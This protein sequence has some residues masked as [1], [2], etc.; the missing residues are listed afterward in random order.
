MNGQ[1]VFAGAYVERHGHLRRDQEW[2]T[3]AARSD[4]SWFVPVWGEWCLAAGEPVHTVLLRRDAVREYIDEN[5]LVFLGKFR[6]A[7]AFAVHIDR[8]IPAPFSDLG[9]FHDLRYLGSVLP[10]DEANLV[11]HARALIIWNAT[12]RFCGRCGA[13]TRVESGGNTRMCVNADCSTRSFPRVDPAIIVL[14][15]KGD[16]CL[17]GRE[18]S[19][20]EGRYST[21]AG[22][23]EPG[24]SLED[25]VVREVQ[26][27]TNIAVEDVVYHSSQPWPFPA[28]IMLG[29][30]ARGTTDAVTRNDGE[31]EDAR[32]FTRKELAS[33]YPKLS[34][35]LSI[36]RTLI[37][38]WIANEHQQSNVD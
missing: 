30:T 12:Q 28:S 17:L 34:P 20:P 9:K 26:E 23:V 24:E 36:S 8:S 33:G 14:V 27:E 3:A 31:L 37:E 6:G 7:P 16:R 10:V 22:F 1:N 2:L 38:T 19:W 4:E 15:H 32:W 13:A 5:E 18:A 35:R 25:A 29:F 21:I 11:A